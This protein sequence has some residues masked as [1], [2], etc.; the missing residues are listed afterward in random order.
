MPAYGCCAAGTNTLVDRKRGRTENI[1]KDFRGWTWI[2][3]LDNLLTVRCVTAGRRH[4]PFKLFYFMLR[5]EEKVLAVAAGFNG[6]AE[7]TDMKMTDHR[8]VQA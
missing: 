2:E 1:L 4:V 7:M 5:A 8:N 6:G 3:L